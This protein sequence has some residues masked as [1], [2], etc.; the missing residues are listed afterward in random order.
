MNR[1]V[2]IG[3]LTGWLIAPVLPALGQQPPKVA[4]IGALSPGS[5][6]TGR[7]ELLRA[8]KEQGY[9]EGRNA[10]IEYRWAEREIGRLSDLAAELVRLKVDVIIARGS[11]ATQA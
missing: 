1:R 2:V 9:V 4:R 10:V 5:S 8:L 7:D 11:E 3:A 6:P